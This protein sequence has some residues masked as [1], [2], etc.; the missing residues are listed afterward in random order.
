[1]PSWIREHDGIEWYD[2]AYT[3]KQTNQQPNQLHKKVAAGTLRC[4]KDPEGTPRWYARPDVENLREAFLK[5][6][7]AAISRKPSDEE[8][9]ARHTRSWKSN[10]ARERKARVATNGS[11]AHI[12]SGP[13]AL[14]HERIMLH[15]IAVKNGMLKKDQADD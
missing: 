9:E 4:L 12:G 13:T 1:M 6:R 14:H 11:A 3:T 2:E 8:L 10:I 7:K 5:R 15:E